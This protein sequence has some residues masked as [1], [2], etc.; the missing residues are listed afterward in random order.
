M[1]THSPKERGD[2]LGRSLITFP[3]HDEGTRFQRLE[4]R[5]RDN[6]V[7]ALPLPLLS[8]Y[9]FYVK[10][11]SR[12]EF[13]ILGTLAVGAASSGQDRGKLETH[14]CAIHDFTI[15]ERRWERHA[16]NCRFILSRPT[17]THCSFP[18]LV[19]ICT[20]DFGPPFPSN[21]F[22]M[23]A[24]NRGQKPNRD[25]TPRKLKISLPWNLLIILPQWYIS[26]FLLNVAANAFY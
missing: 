26:F 24:K 18:I 4:P 6:H 22:T 25:H 10:N 19:E 11:E 20:L 17:I 23:M 13:A 14:G 1:R 3:A 5:S 16:R 9:I 12:N 7:L 15:G 21:Q 8:S 2:S